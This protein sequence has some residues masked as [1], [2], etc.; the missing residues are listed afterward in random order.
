M[1]SRRSLYFIA[2]FAGMMAL[3][4]A[5][6]GLPQ[7]STGVWYGW[8]FVMEPLIGVF[9]PPFEAFYT[10]LLGVMVGHVVGFRGDMYEFLFALGAPVGAYVSSL[11]FRGRFKPIVAY[12]VVALSAY[13]LTPESRSLPLW[14]LWDTYLAFLL[15]LTV[16]LIGKRRL[17]TLDRT[18]LLT[19][20][21]VVGLEADILLRIFFFVPLGTY[22]WLYGFSIEYVQA[23]WEVSAFITPIQVGIAVPITVIV[24][25]AL[26][27]AVEI[28]RKQAP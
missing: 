9:F 12:Y 3:F 24:G 2:V 7:L 14:A 13:F 6:P 4:D 17:G 15:L 19:T 28:L 5:A 18:Y 16:T 20:S 10:A 25:R 11:A 1:Q 26:A 27:G 21:T 23:I 8:A 22:R